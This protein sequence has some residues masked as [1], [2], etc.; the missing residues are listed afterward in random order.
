MHQKDP[1]LKLILDNTKDNKVYDI[2]RKILT[3]KVTNYTGHAETTFMSRIKNFKHIYPDVV[4][5]DKEKL[6]DLRKTLPSVKWKGGEETKAIETETGKKGRIEKR[7][8]APTKEAEQ[9]QEKRSRLQRS[10]KKCH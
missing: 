9:S 3:L 1:V 4:S 5:L 10:R 6:E 8:E 7:K 2:S